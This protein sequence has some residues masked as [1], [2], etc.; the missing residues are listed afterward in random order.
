VGFAGTIARVTPELFFFLTTVLLP[1]VFFGTAIGLG[2][3]KYTKWR[4]ADYLE[5]K[6]AV[7]GRLL[8]ADEQ[9]TYLEAFSEDQFAQKRAGQARTCL[10]QAFADY[11]KHFVSDTY[12]RTPYKSAAAQVTAQLVQVDQHVAA[13]NSEPGSMDRLKAVGMDFG[14]EVASLAVAHGT[15]LLAS[16][17]T[18]LNKIV[19]G[20]DVLP[21]G[22]TA[23][24][25]WA[26]AHKEEVSAKAQ[27]H[28][29]AQSQWQ[30]QLKP[31]P[32]TGVVGQTQA[33]ADV[34]GRTAGAAGAAGQASAAAGRGSVP[35]DLFP[36][37]AQIPQQ[38]EAQAM[39][40][41]F[42]MAGPFEAE[43]EPV[44]VPRAKHHQTS[45]QQRRRIWDLEDQPGA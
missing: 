17:V 24:R 6:R 15:R 40:F 14:R 10:N 32:V 31:D 28:Q 25:A 2:V 39:P 12:M 11:S 44:P 22:V 16:G 21:D 45:Q 18:E 27:R 26:G 19:A 33:A 29:Y 41:P 34:A 4:E 42:P 36:E 37:P 20:P 38:T 30:S 3:R 5:T 1:M 8:A 7:G 9:V 43:A 23:P 35:A 13:A